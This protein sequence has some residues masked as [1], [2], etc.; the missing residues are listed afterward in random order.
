MEIVAKVQ[1]VVTELSH[2][3]EKSRDLERPSEIRRRT[4]SDML[5]AKW[6][7]PYFYRARGKLTQRSHLVG[8]GKSGCF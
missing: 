1:D 6:S 4:D 7:F 3:G 5:N 2:Q 8:A